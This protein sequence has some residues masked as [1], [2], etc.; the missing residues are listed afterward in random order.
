M[1]AHESIPTRRS[2]INRLK[3][4]DDQQSWR[5][6][7]DTYWKLI[8]GVAIKTGLSDGQA[9]DIVQETLVAVAKQ[10]PDFHYDPSLG[11]FKGWLLSITRRRIVDF[12]RKQ[13]R[14]VPLQNPL[15]DPS[16]QTA[17]IE[18][19]PAR[20]ADEFEALWDREW[21]AHVLKAAVRRVKARVDPKQFQIYDCYVLKDWPVKDVTQML[22]VSPSQVYL[23]KHRIFELLRAEIQT[24][25]TIGLP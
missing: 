5:D 12:L 25:E 6:F 19:I 21:Q 14:Q 4:W 10:M 15:S 1:N 3:D 20:D 24:L 13:G 11:S 22:A 18:K 2:L 16:S 17:A 8:Y 7:F 9:Q 23:A